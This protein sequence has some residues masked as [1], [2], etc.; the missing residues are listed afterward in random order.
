[1]VLAVA[2]GGT[3][4]QIADPI[5]RSAQEEALSATA[6]P[7]PTA[8]AVA[9][10]A[11]AATAVP[12]A[13]PTAK[14]GKFPEIPF[15]LLKAPEGNPKRGGVLRYAMVIGMPHF[16]L[17]QA[18]SG[19]S[20]IIQ[21]PTVDNLVRIHPL[22]VDREVIP[23]LAHSW[24]IS[25]D[26]KTY[27]FYLR[28]GVKFHDGAPLTSDDVKA[29]F[30][31]IIFPPPGMISPREPNFKVITVKEIRVVD[32]L[33]VQFILSEPRS[34]SLVLTA[35]AA[36]YNSI[37][38]KQT[39]EDNNFDL[40]RIVDYP[41]TGPFKFVDYSDG[42]FFEMEAF[43]DYWNPELPYLDGVK[44]LHVNAWTPEVA[45][46]ILADRADF[47]I[48]VEPQGCERMIAD[49]TMT[50][51]YYPQTV[52][53]ALWINV[54]RPPL[55]DV[56]V[57]RAIHL[58]IDREAIVGVVKNTTP[59]STGTGFIFKFNQ[60][61]AQPIEVLEQRPGYRKPKDQDIADGQA[62]LAEA[63]F[64]NGEGFPELDFLVRAVAHFDLHAVALQEMLRVHLN[65]KSNIRSQQVG[66]W[67]EDAEK[68]NFDVTNGAVEWASA[69]PS[70]A[71][72]STYSAGAGQNYGHWEN[73]EFE[74]Y[75]D[76][77]DRELDPVKRLQLIHDAELLLEQE[78]P[79]APLAYEIVT[80][81]YQND[82]K[83]LDV[84]HN[85]GVYDVGR[86][87]TAWLDN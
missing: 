4:T 29:T 31:R 16:D 77:I 57:R 37:V 48:A 73:A 46:A 25:E 10:A 87:D 65:I 26:G 32:P 14:V 82:V 49:P 59:M 69:E 28:E 68:G 50:C 23:D 71:F 33:T 63:G 11:P 36:G 22:S 85:I 79:L 47:G 21:G 12:V 56:R 81:G 76:Q 2:C 27:T 20:T 72:R 53:F 40:K 83:G 9:T 5:A 3:A 62:L 78:V 1:M 66:V 60:T 86:F 6:T 67:F 44:V 7:A 19:V 54:E 34:P 43:E 80:M 51:I 75:L 39:L 70:F 64:P 52:Q 13:V 24:D 74:S 30:D 17:H 15:A 35:F 41:T 45:A 61:Y 42:E 18:A 55:D 8:A 38:R 84:A 58:V